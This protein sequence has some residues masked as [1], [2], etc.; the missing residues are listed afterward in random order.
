MTVTSNNACGSATATATYTVNVDPL[1]TAS[2]GGSE[3]IC[4]NESATVSGAS[5]NNGDI[6]WT[7]NGAGS[8]SGSTTLTPIYTAA[9]GDAGSSVTLTMTVTSDNACGSATAT[10]TY[11]VN[12]DP[13]PT[14]SAGGSETICSNES[15]TVSGASADNGDILWTHDGNGNITDETTLT[16]TYTAVSADEGNTVTLTMTVTST[17]CSNESATVSGASADNGDILWTHDGNGNITDK[18]TMTPTYTAVLADAGSSV[19]LTMTV[20]SNNACS[21]QTATA[22]YTINVNPMPAVIPGS[23]SPVCAGDDINLTETGGDAN[24]WSWEGPDGFSSP[25]Q[26]PVI[27]SATTDA[28]GTYTV[29][30]TDIHGCTNTEDIAVTVYSSPVA[31]AGSN[32]PV[33]EGGDINLTES[34]GNATSWS[35]SGPNGFVSSNHNPTN[36]AVTLS[37]AGTYSVTITDVSGCTNSDDVDVIVYKQP[38]AVAGSNSPVCVGEDINLTE[39][40]G[41]GVTW[42]WSGPDGFN[43]TAEDTTIIGATSAADGLYYVTITDSNGCSVDDDTY[44]TVNPT[45]AVSTSSNSPECAGEN[46][47]LSETGGDADSWLWSGPDGFSSTDQ[48]PVIT[49]ATTAASGTYT[50]TITDA[51]GCTN[52]NNLNVTVNALPST[53]VVDIDCSGG[54]GDGIITVTSPTGS[55]YWYN[56]GDGF[57]QNPGFG[58]LDNG[59]YVVTVANTNTGCTIE[60]NTINMDCGCAD[61]TSLTLSS[62]SGSTCGTNPHTVSSNT[63]GGSATE[64]YLSH[65]GNGLLD[66][67]TISASPFDFTYTP[68]A[69]DAGTNVT[70]TIT[71]N[72]PLGSPCIVSQED[73]VLTI[74]SLPEAPTFVSSDMNDFCEDDAGTMNLSATGGSG[75]DLHWYTGSCGDTE[76]GTG[77]PLNIATPTST[78]TYYARWEN[79]CGESTCESTTVT[80]VEPPVDPT[81]ATSD[82]NDFC[83]DDSGNIELSITGGSGETVQWFSGSCGGSSVGS[84]SPLIL[85]SPEATTTYYARWENACG[86]SNCVSHTVNVIP[87]PEAPDAAQTDQNNICADDAGQINLSVTGGVGDEVHWFTGTCGGTEVGTGNPLTLDSPETT[88]EYYARWENACGS[89]S[90]VSTTVTVL[91]IPE[92]PDF[93]S[94]DDNNFCT[95]ESGTVNLSASG[96]TGDTLRWFTGSCGGTEIGTGSPLNINIPATTTTYYARW[97]SSCGESTCESTTINV[98]DEPED[99]VSAEADTTTLCADDAGNITL[100]LIGGTGSNVHWYSGSCGG[101]AVGTGNPISIE[102]PSTTTTYYG[103]YETSCG[104]SNCASVTVN[105]IDIPVPPS[106]A[107]VNINDLCSDGGNTIELSVPD[108]SGDELHWYT[109]SCGGTEVGTGNPLEIAQPTTTTTYYARWENAC[110]QSICQDVTVNIIPASDATI[111]PAGPFCEFD[112]PVVITAAESG[113]TWDG[114][115]I[116]PSSGLFDPEEA[117]VGDH[118]ITYTISGA[119]GDSDQIS[120]TVYDNFDATITSDMEYCSDD[121]SITLEAN[122]SGG[123]WQG[124]GVSSTGVFDPGEVGTGDHQIIYS[125]SG[126][127]GDADTVYFTVH[128]RADAT[129]YAVD[130]LFVDGDPVML[131]VE[132]PGGTWSGTAIDED[133]GK[134]DPGAAGTETHKVYYTIEQTCG[135]TDSTNITVVEPPIE[136]LLI[137]DVLTP[138]GDG[139]NDTWTIRGVEAYSNVEISIFTRWGDEVFYFSGTGDAYADPTTQWDGTYNGKDLPLGSY[140]Y[141]LILNNDLEFK[142][143]MTIIR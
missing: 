21:P 18:T 83:A 94:S 90:C 26:S 38:S 122:T 128:Q 118:T 108:G 135:D 36:S 111:N 112:S 46:I 129:I 47:N 119:C 82:I 14:A 3:T 11:T 72:N 1:P 17:I 9:S 50:V 101:T 113:G 25:D 143:T 110:G 100:S 51:N 92:A 99:P 20:T 33:C 61:P 10:A 13:L 76:I 97:E 84:G 138:N 62:T 85:P 2:A 27:S 69:S 136:D 35:W 71:T 54:P 23:N 16:P 15:A 12:V 98:I 5:A 81:S 39:T 77:N 56:I 103:R 121:D 74:L 49:G 44:V 124:N 19:T 6:M 117:G 125:Y 75:D 126:P 132:E 53:P 116:E 57:Q 115:G 68:D 139:L 30:I 58:S 41:D 102:S 66:A 29:T 55:E 131:T 43:S 48:N 96:G 80:V 87:L 67:T 93:V 120:V 79:S 78:T 42:S 134:F 137:P 91:D 95:G 59:T 7:H 37:D 65:D 142:G 105:V 31:I 88:T 8:L 123:T 70:I 4:S 28:D 52:A 24:F 40:G 89:S 127:C 32:S 107:S 130:T 34:G 133:L 64:V 22:T 45:P 141:V 106:D 114:N 140:V 109:E 104:I 86:E 60:G 63:F 73:Y